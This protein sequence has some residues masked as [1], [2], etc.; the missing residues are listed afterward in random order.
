LKAGEIRKISSFN[1]FSFCKKVEFCGGVAVSAA[2]LGCA[3]GFYKPMRKH[4]GVVC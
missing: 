3:F 1:N 2:F 4:F